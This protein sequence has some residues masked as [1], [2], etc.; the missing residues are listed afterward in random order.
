MPVSQA[1]TP[2]LVL[3]GRMQCVN[4]DAD[5][6]AMLRDDSGQATQLAG[7]RAGEVQIVQRETIAFR[8]LRV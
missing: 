2:S 7:T 4:N 1:L 8:R 5:A 6:R 3:C